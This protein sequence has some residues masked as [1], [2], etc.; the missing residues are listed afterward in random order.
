MIFSPK[1]IEAINVLPLF[2]SSFDCIERRSDIGLVECC[3][4]RVGQS[5]SK[6]IH[7]VGRKGLYIYL[8][9]YQRSVIF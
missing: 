9:K 6:E 4:G 7:R 5:M 3:Y 1:E 8:H 2:A